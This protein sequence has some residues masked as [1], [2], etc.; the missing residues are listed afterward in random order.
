MSGAQKIKTQQRSLFVTLLTSAETSD[1]KFKVIRGRREHIQPATVAFR[2]DHLRSRQASH[3][4]TTPAHY[5]GM[6]TGISPNRDFD[7]VGELLM[8]RTAKSL[9]PVVVLAIPPAESFLGALLCGPFGTKAFDSSSLSSVPF[10]EG[11]QEEVSGG[12]ESRG[13]DL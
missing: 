1:E 12:S 7:I 5:S 6:I 2:Y 9:G 8:A 13:S 10:G 3:V 11:R 4:P